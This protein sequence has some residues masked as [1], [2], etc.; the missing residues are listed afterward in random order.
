[1]LFEY[2]C[3]I[4]I[5]VTTLMTFITEPHPLSEDRKCDCHITE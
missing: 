4:Q 1:M 2:I 3:T 5:N